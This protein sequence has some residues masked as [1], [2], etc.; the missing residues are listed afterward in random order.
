MNDQNNDANNSGDVHG[1]D[2]DYAG[3]DSSDFYHDDNN[4]Y[5]GYDKNSDSHDSCYC[6]CFTHVCK[7]LIFCFKY[8]CTCFALVHRL[9]TLRG[10][11]STCA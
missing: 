1:E 3:N 2:D 6:I 8:L 5:N 7:F 10:R 4:D 11:Y 9:R